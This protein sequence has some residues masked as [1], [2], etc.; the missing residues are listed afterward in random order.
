M[1]VRNGSEHVREIAYCALDAREA[2]DKFRCR[3]RPSF[4]FRVRIGVHSGSVVSG[5]VGLK[6][7]KYCLFGD[8]INTGKIIKFN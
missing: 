5:V 6:M 7:P 1:P 8:T 4:K 2:F 3:H